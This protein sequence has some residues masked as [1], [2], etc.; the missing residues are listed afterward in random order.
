MFDTIATCL[1]TTASDLIRLHKKRLL[2]RRAKIQKDQWEER[3]WKAARTK[4]ELS[5]WIYKRARD[6]NID[7]ESEILELSKT[8]PY[9][10]RTNLIEIAKT[11]PAS[12]GGK[13]PALNT[14][15]SWR[16]R[17]EVSKLQQK[18]MSKENAYKE[19]A[20][21]WSESGHKLSAHTVRRTYDERERERSRRVSKQASSKATEKTGTAFA[22][23]D[24][25][26]Y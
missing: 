20:K 18:G 14:M 5:E 9:R 15:E 11:I 13:R 10:V 16:V 21:R 2:Y 12:R 4:K 3:L 6:F 25:D 19:V 22:E 24:P 1:L 7:D 8:I 17:S 23:V 26:N